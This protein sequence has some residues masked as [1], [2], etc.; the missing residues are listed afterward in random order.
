[1]HLI[2]LSS[3]W[4]VLYYEIKYLLWFSEVDS[5]LEHEELEILVA[6]IRDEVS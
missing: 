1:M 5:K 3:F 6:C 4:E 2:P